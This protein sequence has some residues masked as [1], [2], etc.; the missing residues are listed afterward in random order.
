MYFPFC[1]LNIYL[2]NFFLKNFYLLNSLTFVFF[3]KVC[4][5]QATGTNKSFIVLYFYEL[6]KFHDTHTKC[7][8]DRL[9]KIDFLQLRGKHRENYDIFTPATI[10]NGFLIKFLVAKPY[11]TSN[12]IHKQQRYAQNS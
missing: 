10:R 6:L 4:P 9:F 3:L 12:S 8:D 7:F 1:K 11:R 5:R 2:L